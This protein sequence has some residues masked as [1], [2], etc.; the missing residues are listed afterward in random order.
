MQIGDIMTKI[1]II[2]GFLGAGKTT[3]IKK[4]LKEAL[5]GTKVVLIE[6]EFGEIGI[7]GGF[8]KESGIEITEMNSGCICCS[9]VGDFETSLKQVMDQYAPERILIEPSGVGKLSDVM[10]AIQNIA[11]GSENM[12]LNSAVTVV[13]VSKAKVYIK[14]FGEFFLN[15]IENA[16]T[17]ILTRTDKADQKKIEEAV[18]LIR[19]HNAKATI[20]TTPLDEISGKEILDTFE[21]N[22]DIEAELLKMIMEEKSEHHHHHHHHG[23][24]KTVA[25]DGSVVYSAHHDDEECDDEECSCHHHHHDDDEDEH[26]HHHHHHDDED[27]HEHEHHH[28]HDEDEH[29]HEHEHHHHHHDA[30]DVFVSWGM[31]TPLKYTKEEIESM[32]SKLEDE[33]KYGIVL[34]TKGVVPSTDGSWIEFDYVPGEADVRTGSADVTGKFCVI[35]SGLVEENLEKLFRRLA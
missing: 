2:S 28:H 4:L 14:N 25:E 16:G 12:E 26:E 11:E 1:D 15:Q 21:G 33:E 6:N 22:N 29:E 19:E 10:K 27:E 20:I 23:S 18:A 35:G 5:N 34:R 13:D 7:D 31:E 32:L 9:L 17:I 8:L 3:L 24:H 30:A